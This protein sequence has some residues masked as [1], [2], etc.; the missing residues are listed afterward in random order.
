[1]FATPLLLKAKGPTLLDLR[2]DVLVNNLY[3]ETER[4]TYE[5]W[6]ALFTLVRRVGEK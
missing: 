2:K 5:F 3:L 6:L 4:G 1:M